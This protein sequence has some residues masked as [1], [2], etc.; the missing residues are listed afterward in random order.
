MEWWKVAVSPGSRGGSSLWGG[1]ISFDC[2]KPALVTELSSRGCQQTRPGL[3][4]EL[5]KCPPPL[6]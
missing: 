4:P 2:P 6:S 1:R 3:D 5:P